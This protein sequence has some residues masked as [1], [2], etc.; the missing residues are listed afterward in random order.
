MN[1][2]AVSGRLPQIPH[3]IG[4][5]LPVQ[6]DTEHGLRS[7]EQGVALDTFQSSYFACLPARFIAGSCP[8]PLIRSTLVVSDVPVEVMIVRR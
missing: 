3:G 8:H 1:L 4:S 5:D 2:G 7:G 6:E